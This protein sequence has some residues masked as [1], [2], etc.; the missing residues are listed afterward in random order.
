[1]ISPGRGALFYAP[2]VLIALVGLVRFS[3][4]HPWETLLIYGPI[5]FYLLMVSAH[6]M[7]WGG[8]NWGPR[9]LVPVM[10]LLLLPMISLVEPWVVKPS[11]RWAIVLLAGIVLWSFLTQ[12]IGVSIGT[13]SPA[14][15]TMEP[16]TFFRWEYAPFSQLGQANK[17]S[18]DLAWLHVSGG[19][20]SRA[21]VVAPVVLLILL[22]AVVLWLAVTRSSV[23]AGLLAAA[24]ACVVLSLGTA[25]WSVHWYSLHDTRY[26]SRIG[27]DLAIERVA[28]EG[29]PGDLLV[30]DRWKTDELDHIVPSQV[31]NFCGDR[32]PPVEEVV[33]DYWGPSEQLPRLEEHLNWLEKIRWANQRVWLIPSTIASS[34]PNSEVQPW[35]DTYLFKAGCEQFSPETKLC[36]YYTQTPSDELSPVAATPG[37]RSARSSLFVPLVI[38]AES[39]K[40]NPQAEGPSKAGIEI[41]ALFG[42][43]I[44]LNDVLLYWR[45]PTPQQPGAPVITTPGEP[46]LVE[47]LWQVLETVDKRY[48]VSLQL[49]DAQ[50]SL[51]HQLDREPLDGFFPITLW[52][53]RQLWSDRYAFVLPADLPAGTYQLNLAVYDPETGARL[54]VGSGDALKLTDLTVVTKP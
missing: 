8:W 31:S 7:W 42:D 20:L 11:P 50:G 2:I 28:A 13:N 14:F 17:I 34:N 21:V 4:R 53:V 51:V 10:P 47:L 36:L 27:L 22:S 40:R 48:K 43:R 38:A 44:R 9:Y 49:L 29:K 6:P 26:A 35:F 1:M 54:P 30:Y 33:L 5:P 24:I 15:E 46:L 52:P 45:P 3:R 41:D 37:L 23:T 18:L 32:C 19:M 12:A 25:V 39:P 16:S